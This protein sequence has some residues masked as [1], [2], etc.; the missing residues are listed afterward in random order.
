MRV[1]SLVTDMCDLALTVVPI[2]F[3]A[4]RYCRMAT[5]S[6]FVLRRDWSRGNRFGGKAIVVFY[7]SQYM[8]AVTDAL[9]V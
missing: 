8:F 3:K 7:I 1:E 2:Q 9:A 4:Y 6:Y 5:F